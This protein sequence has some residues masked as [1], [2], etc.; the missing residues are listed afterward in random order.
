[1]NRFIKTHIIFFLLIVVSTFSYAQSVKRLD[2]STISTNTLDEKINFLIKAA[3]VHGLAIAVFND[4]KTVYKKT[5]GY[6]RNDLKQPLT[7]TTNFYGA[8]LSKVVFAVL[9]MKLVEEGIIDLDTPLE[10][11][12]SKPIYEY[13][14]L[15]RWHDNYTDL[16]SDSL[17]KH[18]TARMCLS[19]TTGFAN[20][21]WNETD[22]KLKV[23]FTPGT[24][25]S[26]SGDGL[27]YLQVVL[28][29]LLGKP[30]N[31]LMNDKIF[32]PLKMQNSAYLWKADFEKDYASGH[33]TNGDIYEKDKDNEPR[34]AS[35]L[36]TTLNDYVLF[37]EAV[38]QNK[39]LKP[40]TTK[41]MFA[42]QLRIR[43]VQHFGPLRLKDSTLNDAIELS[44]GLGWV[45]LKS[46]YGIGAFKEGH[47]D[48]F[49]HYSIL[50][51]EKGIG[52][53]IMTN[54]DNG[55]SIFKELLEIAIADTFTPWYWDNYI[56]YNY[57]RI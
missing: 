8:S 46:P 51:P 33:K 16:R 34:A 10:T 17:Y 53:V 31:E 50:F 14:P 21:R 13:L 25:Y 48:G 57:T 32:K 22:Q 15:T 9:V 43:S 37:S 44:S 18:I 20:W 11:Y 54:S 26:Y 40:S 23:N 45:I 30:L 39:I 56:P 5:F 24:K 49:Q 55:E 1:L 19:H 4:N 2:N 42:P 41:E 28:E 12:L 3:N 38:L 36:E 35:T 47:G 29:K 52:I 6:K 7:T 27:V